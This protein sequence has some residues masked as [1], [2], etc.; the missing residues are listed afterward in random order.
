MCTKRFFIVIVLLFSVK[1]VAGGNPADLTFFDRFREGGFVKAIYDEEVFITSLRIPDYNDITFF[2]ISCQ[3]RDFTSKSYS[4][5]MIKR[6]SPNLDVSLLGTKYWTSDD[7]S[8]E[9]IEARF[10][11]HGNLFELPVGIG[12]SLPFDE[13]DSVKISP[14]ITFRELAT[15]LTISEEKNNYLLGVDYKKWGACFGAAYDS[16]DVWHV[17]ISKN[18]KVNKR[19]FFP[20]FR[21]KITSEEEVFGLGFGMSF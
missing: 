2:F 11:I 17:R 5:R 21:L 3:N 19:N 14:R 10:D 16:K 12:V 13:G 20:E 15:Y 6:F 1:V 8:F 9:K 4:G 18:V 7:S